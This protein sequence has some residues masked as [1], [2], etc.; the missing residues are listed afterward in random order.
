MS[1]YHLWKSLINGRIAWDLTRHRRRVRLRV[2]TQYCVA[3]SRLDIIKMYR[4]YQRYGVYAYLVLAFQLACYSGNIRMLEQLKR[5]VNINQHIV[6][7]I[8]ARCKSAKIIKYLYDIIPDLLVHVIC[9]NHIDIFL[10][11]KPKYYRRAVIDILLAHDINAF[12]D[13]KGDILKWVIEDNDVK[14]FRRIIRYFDADKDAERYFVDCSFFIPHCT[15]YGRKR[16][17]RGLIQ[18]SNK[19]IHEINEIIAQDGDQ[20]FDN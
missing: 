14:M 13:A 18:H 4:P 11:E 10:A 12:D 16:I 17:M 6:F 5:M 7:Q 9:N 3:Y 8:L 15:K 20:P 1:A 19:P 2:M